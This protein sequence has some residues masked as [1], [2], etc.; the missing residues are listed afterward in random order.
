M[1]IHKIIDHF[2]PHLTVEE[3]EIDVKKCED[4]LSEKIC[5]EI[6]DV[7]KRLKV[8][9]EEVDKAIAEAAAKGITKAHELIEFVR[10]KIVSLATKFG[11]NDIMPQKVC[12]KIKELAAKF[13]VS[14]A[15]VE[16]FIKQIVSKGVTSI[17][18]IIKKI[19]DKFFPSVAF[20]EFEI[21]A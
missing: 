10:E 5:T 17:H 9:V 15:K 16:E 12:D 3:L 20:S 1:G 7:A 2:F 21:V 19:I 14:A 18:E 8:K 13:K 6:R 11:C 4:L